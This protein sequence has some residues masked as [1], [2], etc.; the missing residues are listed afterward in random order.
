MSSKVV[1]TY[2]LDADGLQKTISVISGKFDVEVIV[3]I[4]FVLLLMG[5]YKLSGPVRFTRLKALGSN[6]IR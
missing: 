4:P 1:S 5:N 2:K 6:L 3:V